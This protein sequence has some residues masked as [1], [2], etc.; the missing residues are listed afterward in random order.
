MTSRRF[1][2]G[3]HTIDDRLDLAGGDQSD[4][5]GGDVAALR[6]LEAGGLLGVLEAVL[7]ALGQRE[8]QRGVMVQA[9]AVVRRPERRRADR[10]RGFAS[11]SAFVALIALLDM[12]S[13]PGASSAA[14]G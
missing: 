5:G 4:G 7:G 2:E 3:N 13:N 1:R 6:R 14:S 8:R 10:A 9:G 11:S 12:I